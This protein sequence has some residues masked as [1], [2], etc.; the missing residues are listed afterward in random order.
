MQKLFEPNSKPMRIAVFMSGSGINAV[1]IIEHQNQLRLLDSRQEPPYKVVVIFTDNK[2]EDNES[3]RIG[4]RFNIPVKT[5]DLKN[6]MKYGINDLS[7]RE[8]YFRIVANNLKQ[9]EIDCIVLADYR[10][11]VTDPLISEYRNRIFNVHPADLSIRNAAGEA[12]YTGCGAVRA[13]ILDGRQDIRAS[14]HI[15][16]GRLDQG[17]PLLISKPLKVTLSRSEREV[18]RDRN[19]PMHKGPIREIADRH[20]NKLK[21]IGDLEIY[22]L[23]IELISKGRFTIDKKGVVQLDGVAI[24]HGRKLDA[25]LLHS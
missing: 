6:M 11:I 18:L 5:H 1:K 15:V 17:N 12:I 24:P 3:E 21:E 4:N 23:T 13:A 8:E 16:T 9:Y 19:N 14:T 20:Q 22:P 10:L 25:P 7:K 2:K